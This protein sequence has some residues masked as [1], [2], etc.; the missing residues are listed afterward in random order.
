[1][2]GVNISINATDGCVNGCP[3]FDPSTVN[4]IMFSAF[5]GFLEVSSTM[6]LAYPEYREKLGHTF[7]KFF[8][9]SMMVLNLVFMLIAS[10]AYIF[11]SWFGPVSLSVPTVMV[12]KLLFNLIIMGLVLKMEKLNKDQIVGTFCIACAILT[13][14]DVGPTDQPDL[15]VIELIKKPHSVLWTIALS[16]AT[17]AC[18]VGMVVL[19][20]RP[21]PA[22]MWVNLTIYVMAQVVSAVMSTSV[23]KMFPLVGGATLLVMLALAGIFALINVV[24]LILAATAVDQ[25]L[26]VPATVMATIVVNLATGLIIWEDWRVIDKWRAYLM[27]HV[28]MR[29]GICARAPPRAPRLWAAAQPC[30]RAPCLATPRPRAHTLE[31]QRPQTCSRPPTPSRSTR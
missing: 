26:F 4:C 7:T 31:T 13:L 5:G 23:S 18:C 16:I 19:A 6:C 3:T 20:R 1:M 11:G 25:G 8:K 15:D 28:I 2:A 30:P 17:V 21:E 10:F 12:S 27:V 9:G 24:S 22:P 29:L 14:P